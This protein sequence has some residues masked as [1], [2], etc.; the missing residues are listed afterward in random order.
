MKYLLVFCLTVLFAGPAFA[1]EKKPEI[2]NTYSLV[3]EGMAGAE[4]ATAAKAMLA[5]VK[6][7]KV[8]TCELKDGKIEATVTSKN[9]VSRNDISKALKERKEA[10][11]KEFKQQRAGKK[12]KEEAKPEAPKPEEPA[13]K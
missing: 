5:K 6:D 2:M 11:V 4:D 13:K 3:I 8:D 9:R 10:K 1:Q 7:L 12:K